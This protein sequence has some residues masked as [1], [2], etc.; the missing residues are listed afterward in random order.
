MDRWLYRIVREFRKLLPEE[1]VA[2]TARATSLVERDREIESVPFFWSFLFGTTQPDGSVTKVQEFYKI[3]TDHDAAYSSIQQWITTE[4]KSLLSDIFAHISSELGATEPALGGRFDRF[5]DV[6]IADATDC[7]LSMGSFEEF[8][9]YGD[10]HAGARLHVIESLASRAPFFASITDV[11]TGELSQLQIDDWLTDSLLLDDLGYHDYGKI[12]QIDESGGWFVNRLKVDSNAPITD[13]LRRWR[14]NAISLEGK[15]LQDVLPDLYRSE[16]DVT[17]SFDTPSSDS[18]LLPCEFRLVG[19]R[20]D[21]ATDGDDAP[22]ADHDYH[23]YVTNLPRKWFKP[24][25]I[26]ALYS[27]R[28]SVETLVQ[29]AKSVFGLEEISV[30]RKEA[31]ECFMLASLLMVLLSRY[32]LRQIRA[33]LGSACPGSV[34]EETETQPMSFSKRLKWYGTD[35]LEMFAHQ[36]G[37]SWEVGLAIIEGAID[38]NL[39]R[40]ALTERVAHGSVD[41]NLINDGEL[42]RLRPG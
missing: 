16:I 25:E 2:R 38:R 12:A 34:E 22:D 9:G 39:N 19:L 26:A 27:N 28:W 40:H 21:E 23:L 30:R 14:G 20:H 5:R 8:P 11:R 6:F 36:L 17:A 7:T 13:E 41:P 35:I 15:Q 4:L 18:E 42:A 3:F 24:R 37:Y 32:L 31:V 1:A 33:G 29:E 10:D